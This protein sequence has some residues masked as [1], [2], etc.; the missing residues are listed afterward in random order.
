MW[1]KRENI[2][3]P[4][5]M[6]LAVGLLLKTLTVEER[7][8]ITGMINQMLI[9]C[10]LIRKHSALIQQPVLVSAEIYRIFPWKGFFIKIAFSGPEIVI[11]L[12]II[13]RSCLPDLFLKVVFNI[14]M[15]RQLFSL[16]VLCASRFSCDRCWKSSIDVLFAICYNSVFDCSDRTFSQRRVPAKTFIRWKR[17]SSIGLRKHCIELTV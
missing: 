6:Q 12:S 17:I 13:D 15:N 14:N 1:R 9:S 5:K 10:I 4:I 2:L 11:S 16:V 3:Y 8:H 7:D